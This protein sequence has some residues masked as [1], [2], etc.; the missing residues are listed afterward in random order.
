M[1][2][3]VSV[4]LDDGLLTLNRAVGVLR[5]RNVPVEGFALGPSGAAG[6]SRLTFST[7]IDAAAVD[8]VA[9]QFKK[10]IG[11][12][13]VLVTRAEAETAKEEEP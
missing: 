13:E 4:L 7:P 6:V 9:Q 12:R 3:A 5:R 10:I 11:V 8:R 1:T 2:H